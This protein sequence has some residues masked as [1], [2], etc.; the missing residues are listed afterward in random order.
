MNW[1]E[2]SDHSKAVAAFSSFP[3]VPLAKTQSQHFISPLCQ[4]QAST[5]TQEQ[6]GVELGGR[7]NLRTAP[8]GSLRIHRD[9]SVSWSFQETDQ[10]ESDGPSVLRLE[11]VP[12]CMQTWGL[13]VFCGSHGEVKKQ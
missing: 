12:F 5:Q 11:T 4:R 1:I 9:L 2:I 3:G 6:Q 7:R 10:A 13:E 8:K